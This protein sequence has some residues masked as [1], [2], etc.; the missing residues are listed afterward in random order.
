MTGRI[1]PVDKINTAADHP[2]VLLSDR[3]GRPIQLPAHAE[4][5]CPVECPRFEPDD[6]DSPFDPMVP[7]GFRW[8][9]DFGAYAAG[10]LDA[11]QLRCVLCG[12]A[13]CA[14]QHC[15]AIYVSYLGAESVCGMT[16]RNGEC[17]RGGTGADHGR[18]RGQS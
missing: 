5:N 2:A 12:R 7:D 6:A 14:C 13:P 1:D 10:E 9:P 8:S 15:T 4:R 11:S 3:A 16:L 18:K 17:P